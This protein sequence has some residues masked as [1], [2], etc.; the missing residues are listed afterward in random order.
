MNLKTY[1]KMLDK[2]KL[3]LRPYTEVRLLRL[4]SL[5]EG[6]V[7]RL[8]ASSVESVLDVL[9]RSRI[10]GTQRFTST[11]LMV[12]VNKV[13]KEISSLGIDK[14]YPFM[15]FIYIALPAVIM[16]LEL[17]AM[18]GGSFSEL[19]EMMAVRKK[20]V[21]ALVQHGT[22]RGAA[23][24]AIEGFNSLE[25]SL[26]NE[27]EQEAKRGLMVIYRLLVGEELE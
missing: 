15:A 1:V 23:S 18:A 17:L 2:L 11:H 6:V 8:G 27:Y 3:K 21:R 7:D 26:K 19:N 24:S 10:L 4:L 12:Y 14:K 25:A 16:N 9:K 20:A 5:P 13:V 22:E